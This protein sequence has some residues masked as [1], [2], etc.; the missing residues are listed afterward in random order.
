VTVQ[1]AQVL[2]NPMGARVY[3]TASASSTLHLTSQ[4]WY[5]SGALSV[6]TLCGRPV[7]RLMP[8][9]RPE[10]ATCKVCQRRYELTQAHPPPEAF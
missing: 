5:K 2:T 1:V 7:Y 8:E 4:G 10:D 9:F 3:M 6:S